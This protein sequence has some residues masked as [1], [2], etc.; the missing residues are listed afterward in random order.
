M[1]ASRPVTITALGIAQIL[2]WS[3]SFYFP[4]VLA[5]PI[6]ADTGWSLFWAETACG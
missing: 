3:S 5:E 1:R 2:G 4:A 6:M